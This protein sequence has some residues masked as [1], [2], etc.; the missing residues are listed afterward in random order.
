MERISN[1]SEQQREII[2]WHD[3]TEE[4]LDQDILSSEWEKKNEVKNKR[5]EVRFKQKICKGCRYCS[6]PNQKNTD[7]KL[8]RRSNSI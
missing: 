5:D 6:P 8:I 4:I 7:Q 2:S 1:K 3:F